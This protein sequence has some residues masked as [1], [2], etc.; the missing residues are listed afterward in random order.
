MPENQ[1]VSVTEQQVLEEWQREYWI[2][3][4][5]T[6]G[7]SR[8]FELNGLRNFKV[9]ETTD[10]NAIPVL[11]TSK[12]I[13]INSS[14]SIEGSYDIF[15]NNPIHSK[16]RRFRT[17]YGRD[18]KVSITEILD[19]KGLG[20]GRQ[21]TLYSGIKYNALGL[22]NC[23]VTNTNGAITNLK[24]TCEDATELESFN[25]SALVSG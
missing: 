6:P 7:N 20:F 14:K 9:D 2:S 25:E 5:E 22:S 8:R 10:T 18:P 21:V 17:K 16:I 4:E 24:F 13:N 11:G 19:G 1:F 23:D 15:S 3:Y 12:K